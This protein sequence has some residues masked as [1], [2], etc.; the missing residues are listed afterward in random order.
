MTTRLPA[1]QRRQQIL[2]VACAR[3]RR[4]GLPRHGDGRH[5]GGGGGHEACAL[6]AL[7]VEA[8]V[9]HRAARTSSAASCSTS[10]STATTA[11][12]HT[13][14]GARRG[15]LRRLLPIR[16]RERGGVPG[17]VRRVGPQ[18]FGVRR[19][20][21]AAP[22]RRG[23]GGQHAHRDRGDGS[24]TAG[25]WRTRSS[26]SPRRRAAT[27]STDGGT[28]LDGEQLA[29]LG[30]GARLVRAARHAGRGAGDTAG[31]S[32]RSARQPSV[33]SARQ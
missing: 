16:D 10:S 15:W 23:G 4:P 7:P 17:A 6:P 20:D 22:R 8:G 29:R 26:G 24:S 28:E 14:R 31:R 25:C 2:D 33:P 13:G 19:R 30:V 18:R 3:V 9:V 27:R 12:A 5:R 11:A 32:A 21:R 1:E